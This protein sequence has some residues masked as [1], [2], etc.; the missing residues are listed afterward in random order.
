MFVIRKTVPDDVSKILRLY[1]E[2]AATQGGIIR[3]KEEIT[4]DYINKFVQQS[5]SSGLALVI[6]HPDNKAEIIAE[7]HA[8][9][10][11]LLAFR[12]ILTDLTI[13]VHPS[14]QGQKIGKLIFEHFL[15]QVK[16]KL[17]HILRVELFVRE[18]NAKAIRFY[19]K[20]GFIEEGRHKNK[21]KNMD[22]FLETPVEM[23]WFNPNYNN[24]STQPDAQF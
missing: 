14:F 11:G 17:P 18:N 9:Q 7:I 3:V 20:L 6:T 5:L 13:V 21:I 24:N 22:N 8:Y 4:E 2:I 10:Y 1:Q 23:T 16:E 19:E 12:H 15:A